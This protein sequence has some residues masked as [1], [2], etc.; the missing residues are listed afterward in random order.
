MAFL[1]DYK[2]SGAISGAVLLFLRTDFNLNF[3][4]PSADISINL[5]RL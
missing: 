2:F 3:T 4:Y 1:F 5:K